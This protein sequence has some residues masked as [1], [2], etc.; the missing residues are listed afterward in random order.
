MACAS[1][2]RIF[3]RSL[4]WV[5][6]NVGDDDPKSHADGPNEASNDSNRMQRPD[7]R[8]RTRMDGTKEGRSH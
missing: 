2:G 1:T 7:S 6:R 4:C 5:E 8:P 3:R